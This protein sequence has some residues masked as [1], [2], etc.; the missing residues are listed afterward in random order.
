VNTT[1]TKFDA[2][3]QFD[4]PGEAVALILTQNDPME[5]LLAVVRANVEV[6][7]FGFASEV[8]SEYGVQQFSRT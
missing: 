6:D 2:G 5:A 1:V 3:Q 8:V 7:E 4:S